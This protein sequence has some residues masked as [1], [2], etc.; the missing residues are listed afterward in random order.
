MVKKRKASAQDVAEDA[1]LDFE[2]DCQEEPEEEEE[3]VDA[4]AEANDEEAEEG[5]KMIWRPGVDAIE[6]G[7]QLDV[8]PGTYDMLHRAQVEWPCLSLDVLRDDLGAQRASYPMTAYVVAGSQ[9][10]RTE[11]NRLYVMKWHKLYKTSKDGKED[12]D[13][14]ESEEESEDEHEAALES[15]TTPHPGGVNRVRSMP[16]AGHIVATWADT[17]KVHMWNL[18]A[19]RKALDKGGAAPPVKPIFTNESHTEEGFAMDFSPHETGRFLSGSNDSQ[20]LLWDPA[21][22]GWKIQAEP[23]KAHKS[24]VEDV[25]WKKLGNS[26]QSTFASCSADGSLK[27]WDVREKERKKPAMKV[28]DAHGGSDVNVLSWSPIVGELIVTGADDGGFKIW[29]TRHAAAGPMANF[30]WHRQPV[31]SVDWHPTDETVLAVASADDSVSLWD[32][33]VEDDAP[34]R[35]APQGADH[36]PPQLLFLHQGQKEPKELCW[37]PQLPS[38]CIATAASGF[39]IFKTCNI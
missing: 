30:L 37:H 3:V 27:V 36:F 34:G 13:E 5:A 22:G 6:D 24:S 26:A 10:S 11:D 28:A 35:E 25:Q 9:A 19:H 14:D 32:M 2:D 38:V 12:E 39:N 4:E 29:D 33:A 20:I 21:P 1:D 17:G 15:K 7:E 18:D 16:Q 8:E 23:F 31:T